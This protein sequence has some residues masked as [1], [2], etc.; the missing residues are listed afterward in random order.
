MIRHILVLLAAALVLACS[1]ATATSPAP[2]TRTPLAVAPD[3][4]TP[5]AVPAL[6]ADT[7]EQA[8]RPIPATED[9]LTQIQ[10]AATSTPAVATS[11]P[12]PTPTPPPRPSTQPPQ[13]VVAPAQA[14]VPTQTVAP[15]PPTGAPATLPPQGRPPPQVIQLAMGLSGTAFTPNQIHGNAGDQVLVTFSGGETDHTFTIP[16]LGIDERIAANSTLR[17]GFVVRS[18]GVMPFYCR[19]HG[20]PTS[21]MLGYLVF[22]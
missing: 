19:L 6:P 18:D 10:P 11:T 14:V 16:A 2:L 1:N 3:H 20:S 7:P 8:L 22:H 9:A 13:Q 5:T 15:P 21:G 17:L 4:F 12:A